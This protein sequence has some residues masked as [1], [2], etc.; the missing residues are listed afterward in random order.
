[1]FGKKRLTFKISLGFGLLLLALLAVGALAVLKMTGVSFL[2]EKLDQAYVQQ[3][4]TVSRL[5]RHW[6]QAIFDLRGY[7]MS[8]EKSLLQKGQAS[9]VSV[10]ADLKQAMTLATGFAELSGLQQ[11]AQAG[12][13]L[14]D[15]YE[16]LIT[17]TMEGRDQLEEY[18]EFMDGAQEQFFQNAYQ[19]LQ[20][21]NHALSQDISAGVP[22]DKLAS[23][24]ERVAYLGRIIEMGSQA[25]LARFK[26]QTAADPAVVQMIEHTLERMRGSYDD[27]VSLSRSEPQVQMKV[28]ASRS[29]AE[30]YK[31]VLT[32]W[33]EQ[34]QHLLELRQQRETLAAN[35]TALAEQASEQGLQGVTDLSE[36]T[37]ESLSL[38]SRRVAEG[39]G[40][41]LLLGLILTVVLSRGITRPIKGAVAGL[42]Q[43]AAQVAAASEQI[44]R[45]SQS[46]AEGSAQ[47]A[48]SLEQ[49]STSLEQMTAMTMSN[50]AYAQQ[51]NVLAKKTVQTVGQAG[52][53]MAQ[54]TQSMDSISASG[55]ESGKI[56]KTIEEIAFQTNL[57]ALN[58]AVEAARA[59]QAGAGFAVVAD[60]VRNLALRTS[61][62]AQETATIIGQAQATTQA[63]V[64]LVERTNQSFAQ[65]T[66]ASQ[67]AGGLMDHI[68]AASAEQAQGTGQLNQAVAEMDTVTQQAAASAEQTAAAAEELSGQSLH[69]REVVERLEAMVN[70]ETRQGPSGRALGTIPGLARLPGRKSHKLPAGSSLSLVRHDDGLAYQRREALTGY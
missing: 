48:A 21:Q 14:L 13:A 27:L 57:L 12:L 67:E 7:T 26:V 36:Q 45:A 20:E 58:A 6:S 35:L 47:Q 10:R 5:E 38:A 25:W 16:K 44:S 9:L 55:R 2:Q 51:A 65:V 60:E 4:A 32:A 41:A 49:S 66:A 70:G 19:L 59:G 53:A 28:A 17:Q 15:E 52:A 18:Q 37:V 56:I 40:F 24:Q 29:A 1:M 43:G 54:L 69:M 46:L 33:L 8:N 62:A 42:A 64:E 3:V 23:R 61:R 63:G 30:Q 50:S 39:V 31:S 22:Q 34:R 11:R 68:S